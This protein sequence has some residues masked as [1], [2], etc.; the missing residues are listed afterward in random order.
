MA[1]IS[2]AVLQQLQ[3]AQAALAANLE[4][5]GPAV[6]PAVTAQA[7]AQPLFGAAG[8]GQAKHVLLDHYFTSTLRRFWALAGDAWRHRNVATEDEQGL[9]QVAFMADRVDV[10]WDDSNVVTIVRCWKNF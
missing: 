2:A 4:A 1:E 9:V 6:E 5:Q 7:A 10:W 3:Q 8:S